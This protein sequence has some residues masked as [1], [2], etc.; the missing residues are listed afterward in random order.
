MNV[1]DEEKE[2]MSYIV[3]QKCLNVNLCLTEYPGEELEIGAGVQIERECREAEAN[4]TQETSGD[5][6]SRDIFDD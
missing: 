4:V 5:T 2:W 1:E 6:Q 3:L